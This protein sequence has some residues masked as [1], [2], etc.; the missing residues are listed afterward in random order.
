VSKRGAEWRQYL[1][2]AERKLDIANYHVARLAQELA[3]G[4]DPGRTL[5]P[6][7]VQAHFEGVV[8]SIMAAVDQVSEAVNSGLGLGLSEGERRQ[9]AGKAIAPVVLEVADWYRHPL[10]Q[11]LR[12]IRVLMVHYAYKKMPERG[13]WVIES[14]GSNKYGGS[15]ELATYAKDAV[16]YAERLRDS[17]PKIQVYLSKQTAGQYRAVTKRAT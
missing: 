1:E 5:P 15:R 16:Q 4:N 10:Q 17:I 14:T 6:I 9:G 13:R 11:E 3:M 7:P 12:D 2:A 8:V